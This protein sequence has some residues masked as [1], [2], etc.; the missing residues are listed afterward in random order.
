MP[1]F[2][3]FYAQLL[4]F[5]SLATLMPSA[6]VFPLRAHIEEGDLGQ[7]G[8]GDALSKRPATSDQQK[9]GKRERQDSDKTVLVCYLC[10][11][12]VVALDCC[13]NGSPAMH[14]ER[15]FL[16]NMANLGSLEPR[17]RRLVPTASLYGIFFTPPS[18][19]WQRWYDS[20]SLDPA[21]SWRAFPVSNQP[22]NCGTLGDTSSGN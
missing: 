9:L 8:D 20:Q 2:F 19:F 3:F 4:L 14:L 15:P 21:P 22:R 11:F 17:A 10:R 13:P 7:P 18:T 12:T 5:Q 6:N 16:L 1:C